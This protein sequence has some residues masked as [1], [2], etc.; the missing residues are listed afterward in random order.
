MVAR[1]EMKAHSPFGKAVAGGC[2]SS[3]ECHDIPVPAIALDA[4]ECVDNVVRRAFKDL[5]EVVLGKHEHACEIRCRV[6]SP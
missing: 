4:G 5:Q 2:M 6:A 1:D 3:K